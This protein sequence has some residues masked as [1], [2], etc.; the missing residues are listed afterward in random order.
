MS[1][2]LFGRKGT[3][4]YPQYTIEATYLSE[5][6]FH[7][8]I[9]N[10]PGQPEDTEK[11]FYKP[12]AENLH[13]LSWQEANGN[14]VSQVVNTDTNEIKSFLSYLDENGEKAGRSGT[15]LEGTIVFEN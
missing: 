11:L 8:K 5:T 3:I 2:K 7:W 1:N 9:L 13:F 14:V 6:E 12:L 15:F 4:T 10:L